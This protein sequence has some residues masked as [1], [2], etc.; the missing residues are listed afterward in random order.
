M[1]NYLAIATVTEALSQ[2]LGDIKNDISGAVVVAQPP[3]VVIQGVHGNILNVFLYQVTQ[4]LAHRNPVGPERSSADGRLV[5]KPKLGLDLHYM[6]TALGNDDL[7]AQMILGSAM[8]ILHETPFLSRDL[9]AQTIQSKK[10]LEDSTLADQIEL[11]KITHQNLS[12]EEIAKLWSSFFQ[13]NY[14]ISTTYQANV[15]LLEGK[16][17]ARPTLPVLSSQLK[18]VQFKQPIIHRVEPQILEYNAAGDTTLTII[19]VNLQAEDVTIQIEGKSIIVPTSVSDNKITLTIPSG[20][21]PGIKAVQVIQSLKMGLEEKQAAHKIFKSNVAVFVL[22]PK[23]TKIN[24]VNINSPNPTSVSKNEKLTL[25]FVP[26]MVQ[27]Q[28]AS[29]MIGDY[30]IQLPKQV[31]QVPFNTLSASYADNPALA[32]AIN[33]NP[34][35]T[36]LLRIKV[37]EAES[38]LTVDADKT[39]A[40]FGQ[41]VCPAITVT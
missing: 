33:D 41:F 27:S 1:S 17:E 30:E 20:V 31:S 22:A 25:T 39:S 26:S 8:R 24:G 7:Q 21:T 4:N 12:L 36:H 16:K 11:V 35:K 6:I 23:I 9:I 37:D 10:I 28:K 19:G 40:T 38:L 13:T 29:F 32:K 15:V 5:K 3:D 34:G 14:R 18:V 2:L